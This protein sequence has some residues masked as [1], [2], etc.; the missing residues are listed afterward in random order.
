VYLTWKSKNKDIYQPKQ[1]TE[2]LDIP[3]ANPCQSRATAF[4]MSFWTSGGGG[5]SESKLTNPIKAA[6]AVFGVAIKKIQNSSLGPL[7]SAA[8]PHRVE[9][10]HDLILHILHLLYSHDG[11]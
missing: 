8:Q 4:E 9:V 11:L 7:F 3:I 1:K 10:L 2:L 6:I 5:N